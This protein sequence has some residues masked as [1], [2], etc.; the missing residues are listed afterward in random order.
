MKKDRINTSSI[1]EI[2][3]SFKRFLSLLVMSMLGVLVFVGI[4]MAAPDM[5]QSLDKYY[6]DNN[7][8]DIKVVSTLGLTNDDLSAI[9]KIKNVKEVY[10]SYSKDV[11]TNIKEQ[12]LVLKLIGINDKVNKVKILEG[13]APKNN[14][15]IVI[16]KAMLDKE[17]LK[18]GDVITIDDDVIKNKKLKVV[19]IVKSPLYIT[20]SSGTLNRGNTNIGTGKINYYAYV[21]EDNFDIDYY[22]EIYALVDNAKKDTSNSNTYNDKISSALKNI[23]K[24]KRNREALRYSEIYNK[25]NDEIK[26]KEEEGQSK[27]N[28]AKMMLDKANNELTSGKKTLDNSKK[29][30]DIALKELKENKKKLDDAKITL[31]ENKKKLDSAN[32]EINANKKLINEKLK[33]YEITYDDLSKLLDY[34][35]NETVP[36][37]LVI[38]L[39]PDNFLYRDKVIEVINQIYDLGL[40]KEFIEFLKEPSKKDDLINKIPTDTPGYVEIVFCIN[41]IADNN[42]LIKDYITNPDNIDNIIENIPE[43]MPYHDTIVK[44]LEYYKD[45]PDEFNE[46]VDGIR[47]LK[48]AEK[49]YNC[50]LY[51]SPSPRD[52]KL[53]RMPS[54]A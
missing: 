24:I 51:T 46:F 6:D 16:E 14:N 19:G 22:T 25:A 27:L 30:L 1:R 5:M 18:I 7:V 31:D 38:S 29:K 17:H 12:E 43:D 54:S 37:E 49:E 13:R 21:N 45:N 33:D 34:V 2:K 28:S 39:V 11:L 9:K 52:G 10:G 32:N 8:Y 44:V 4:K 26:V 48:D 20:S 40:D 53:S 15:E 41:F 3:S 50:L 47:K 42:A 35:D 23:D 36:R